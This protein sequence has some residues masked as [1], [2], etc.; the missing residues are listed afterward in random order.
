[1]PSAASASRTASGLAPAA[2]AALHKANV[3]AE[4]SAEAASGRAALL[5]MDIT[6]HGTAAAK[7][8]GDTLPGMASD[9]RYGSDI[10]RARPRKAVA[11]PPVEAVPGLVLEHATSGFCGAVVGFGPGAVILE[12]RRGATRTFPL[13]AGVF[14]VDGGA[15]TV[16]RPRPIAGPAKRSASGSIAMP[17]ARA[18][19]ARASRIWV[20]GIHDATL[21]ERIWGHDLRV[22]GIVVEPLSGLDNLAEA[23]RDFRPA[24]TRRVGVLADHLVPGSKESII[25]AA[26]SGPSVLVTG[27][28]Y[29]DIWQA[30]KPSALGIEAWPV[31]PRGC[32][33]KAGVCRSLGVADIATMW[34]RV[35]GAVHGVHDVETPLVTAVEQLIDFVATPA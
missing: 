20:E 29:V 27:H 7:L 13:G 33:W 35:N 34:G 14:L 19:V 9:D 4:R 24:P 8:T 31:V 28:P 18:R 6:I 2:I 30:V 22:E 25:A 5:V 1:M 32:D 26:A 17:E 21:V 12:D 3:V 16:I 10:L 11:S 15:V 23:L